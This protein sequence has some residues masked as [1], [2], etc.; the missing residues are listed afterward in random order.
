MAVEVGHVE[1]ATKTS[2]TG[3]KRCEDLGIVAIQRQ[4]NWD[5]TCRAINPVIQLGEVWNHDCHDRNHGFDFLC[6]FCCYANVICW[7]IPGSYVGFC[8]RTCWHFSV[9]LTVHIDLICIH[10][11]LTKDRIS[12]ISEYAQ[13]L[14]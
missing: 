8:G 9:H 6:I 11:N 4:W 3:A 13:Q 12:S 10:H 7:M 1:P 5:P 2:K 14:F